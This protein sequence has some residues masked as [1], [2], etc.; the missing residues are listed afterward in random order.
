MTRSPLHRGGYRTAALALLTATLVPGLAQLPAFATS[1]TAA[2]ASPKTDGRDGVVHP[3]GGLGDPVAGLTD[4][5]ARGTALPSAAQRSAAAQLGAVDLRWNQFGTPSSILPADGVLARASSNDP[6]AAARSWLADNAAV[7]GLTRDAVAGMELVN[8]QRLVQS[9]AHAVL[10]RQRFGELTPALASMVTVGVANG[11]IAY[12]SSSLTKTTGTPPAATLSPVQAWVKAAANVG[13]TLDAGALDKI[14]SQVADG[15]TRLSVPG[16][17]QQQLVRLR[18][19]ALADGSVRPVFE[20]NVLDAQLGSAFAYTLMVDGV[21]G[22]I[23]HRQNQAENSSD[24]FQFQGEVTATDCGPKHEFELTD[25]NT[26]QIAAMAAAA[27]TLNDIE[28]KIFDPND[29]LLVTGD[30]GTSPET[31]TYSAD[32]IPAGIYK[33]QVCPF[34]NPTVPFLP[35]GNYV[36]SVT[37]SD[38]AGP[39]TGD[40]GFPSKWRYFTANPSLDYSA[41]TVPSNSVIGCWIAGEGCTSPTGPFRNVAAPGPWDATAN[42]VGTMTTVGNNAN[43]HEAWVSPLTPG[44]TAQAPI[45]PTRE[46]T[47]AFTDAWNNSGCDPAQLTPGGNDIDATVTNLFVAHNRMHDY[48]YY[49][50]F[51]EDNYNMQAD[52]LGRGGVAGDQEIGNAQAGALTG[53]QPS[54][55]GRDNANQITLQDGVPGITNQYLFQP[56]AG[57]FYSPCVDGGLDMGIVG[58]EYTHAISNRMVGG[59][60]EG[61]TSEQGGAM[62][63]SWSDLIAGEYMFSHGYANGGN[64]W[65]VGV[66]ATGNKSVAIRDYAINRNPL[67]YSDYGFDSTGN[68]VHADGEIWNGTQWEVRQALVKKWNKQFPYSDKALQLRCAQ[69]TPTASPLPAGQCPGNRRWVQ[70]VFDSFLLQQGATSMLDARDA[71]LAADRMRFG[72]EDLDVMWKAFARRGMG[73]GASIPNADSGDTTPSFASPRE[74]NGTVSFRSNRSGR[75]FVG[76]YEARA[77]PIADTSDQGKVKTT[78]RLVPGRYEMLY[79]SQAGGFKRFHLTVE[80]G[81]QTVHVNAPTN[82]AARKNGAKV[83]DATA[84]SLNAVSLLDGTEKTAWGGVTATNVDESHPFVV[85]DLAGGVH[86]VRRVQVSAMLNPAPP[87]PNEIPLAQD[88]DPDSGSRFTALRRFALEACVSDCGEAK[89][90]WKRFYVSPGNAFPAVRPRPVAPNLTLRAFE[91]PATRAAAIRFVVLENQC[92]G[93]A[94]YAGEQDNDPIN[95]TDCKTAADRGTI[96]HAAELQVF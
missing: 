6:V 34:D 70:L 46:Y 47:A 50:G 5:D 96:V 62:G 8:D 23:L 82:L 87:D 31:A 63:E 14:T 25:G 4:L 21:S 56:I 84:G 15:W 92:T 86:T 78:A 1:P 35:P 40:I 32:S 45:S 20:T 66:Y 19:L 27:N 30:L 94:G 60:D 49:L 72:G 93:Y 88:P 80:P 11:E 42:G 58:H 39:A 18:A 7:F 22:D 29:Q 2:L 10:F 74:Q 13:R 28:V 83:L 33:L 65:A 79:V 57:A 17:P 26:K 9:D 75:F 37:T 53:G 76:H 48:S 55:L 68:E 91:V 61:L 24:A 89:A 64:P 81:A 54:Y 38:T 59:P 77:T 12:A 90:T 43:T 52:N 69:A 85:V 73:Q 16:Y 36:A 3:L 71:M 44:G 67:N 51:T 95:D 41:K